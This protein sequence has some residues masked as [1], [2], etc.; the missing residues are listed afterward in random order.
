MPRSRSGSVYER[1]PGVWECRVTVAGQT[2]RSV[3]HGDEEAAWTDVARLEGK[4]RRVPTLGRDATL[5][6]VWGAYRASKGQR[7][8]TKT[9]AGYEWHMERFVLPALGDRMAWSITRADVQR[10][11]LTEGWSHDRAARVRRILSAVLSWAEAEGYVPSNPARGG[12]FELPDATHAIDHIDEADDPF[13]AIEGERSVWG[14]DTVLACFDRIRG[15]PLEP[16]WLACVGAGLRVEEALAL[17]RADVRRIAVGGRMVTQLAVHHARTD[18]DKRKATKTARSVRVVAVAEPFGAR[19]WELA[20]GLP[21]RGDLLCPTSASNQNR[22]WRLY[23][24]EPPAEWHP[25]MGESRKCQGRLYGLPYLSMGRMRA[26]NATLME[27]AGVAA[28]LNAAAHGHSEAVSYA[29]YKRPD[30]TEAAQ[31]VGEL[32]TLVG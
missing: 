21:D 7:L 32:L 1:R 27:E 5:R 12:S 19:L 31:R 23:F 10:L 13:A 2:M 3:V 22:A 15:L 8:A 4:L 9:M 18:M 28:D 14:A 24:E 25:R 30:T 20:E 29:H 11:L 17:R 6:A 26:T 16:C